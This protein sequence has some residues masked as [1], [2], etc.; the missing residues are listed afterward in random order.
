LHHTRLPQ[1]LDL[2]NETMTI[3]DFEIRLAETEDVEAIMN[4][5]RG[6][7]VEYGF[8][9]EPE[10]EAPDLLEFDNNYDRR[11]GAFFVATLRERVVGTV[12]LT[13]IGPDTIEIIRLYLNTDF[14]GLGIGR[15]LL[16]TAVDW[17]RQ[18]GATGVT[19]WSD[20][21]FE[22]AHQLYTRAGFIQGPLRHTKDI[23]DSIEYQFTLELCL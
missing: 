14:R 12:G 6:V 9:F 8:I 2:A 1:L 19:L 18:K 17:A 5:M 10:I 15:R 22:T 21:R 11:S 16:E 4:I 3:T 23:N 13:Y 7:Y 20:M